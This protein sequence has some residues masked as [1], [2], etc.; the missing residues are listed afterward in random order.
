MIE[1]KILDEANYQQLKTKKFE[2]AIL[3]LNK[4]LAILED[5]KTKIQNRLYVDK[6][7]LSIIEQNN[8]DSRCYGEQKNFHF[9]YIM[10][11]NKRINLNESLD[12]AQ[13]KKPKYSRTPVFVVV[14]DGYRDNF[15]FRL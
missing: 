15:P 6:A 10:Q 12:M 14:I 8:R 9:S 2:L 4:K 11:E 3:Q 5:S 1:K 7:K 13:N